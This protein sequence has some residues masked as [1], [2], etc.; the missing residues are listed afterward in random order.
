MQR[1]E[2]PFQIQRAPIATLSIFKSANNRTLIKRGASARLQT[3]Y[4]VEYVRVCQTKLGSC[5]EYSKVDYRIEFDPWN[6]DGLSISLPAFYSCCIVLLRNDENVL[7]T[8]IHLRKRFIPD[9]TRV[10]FINVQVYK[11]KDKFITANR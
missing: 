11:N 5:S 2:T 7:T 9:N 1:F 8:A 6:S 10:C 4:V 3:T